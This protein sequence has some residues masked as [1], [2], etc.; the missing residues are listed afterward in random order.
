MGDRSKA[1]PLV[2]TDDLLE[3]D[4]DSGLSDSIVGGEQRKRKSNASSKA[5]TKTSKRTLANS[6]SKKQKKN[7]EDTEFLAELL[8]NKMESE[9]I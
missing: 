1:A 3:S 4:A 5:S 6:A 2:M 8:N 9:A 7:T